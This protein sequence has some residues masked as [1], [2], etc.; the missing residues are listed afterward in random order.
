MTILN[1]LGYSL[2]LLP[3]ILLLTWIVKKD[4][5]KVAFCIFGA[6]I[7]TALLFFVAVMLI[8]S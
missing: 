6:G 2:V 8:T 5:W 4:G 7:I 1:V 3:F